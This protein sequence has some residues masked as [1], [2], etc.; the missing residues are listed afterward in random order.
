MVGFTFS[1]VD[2]KYLFGQIWSKK[3]K[4]SVWAEI[5]TRLIWICRI[6]CKICGV[7]FFCF[8]PE[9]PFLGKSGQKNKNC[10]FKLNLVPRLVWIIGIQWCSSLFRFLSIN[11]SFGQIWSKYSKLFV[12]VKFD[13]NTNSNMQ[14]SMAVSI[15]SVLD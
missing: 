14:S 11:I 1:V 9:K 5:R 2:R 15:L 6:I 4:L 10:Q 13:T 3:S 7:H 8:K 12:I